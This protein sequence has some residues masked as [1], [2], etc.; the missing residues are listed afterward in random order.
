[1][2]TTYILKY[3]KI[4][5]RIKIEELL[6]KLGPIEHES[7]RKDK[8][9]YFDTFDWRLYR[10]GYHLYLFG[11]RFA[12]YNFR[13]NKME[14]TE[15]AENIKETNFSLR[16]SS[17]FGKIKAV[18]GI[19]EPLRQLDL[20]RIR[21]RYRLLNN[22]NKSIAYLQI[23]QDRVKTERGYKKVDQILQITPLRGY[24]KEV[25]PILIKL[26]DLGFIALME[27]RLKINLESCGKHPA[28]YSSK[29]SINLV[30]QMPA[31][32]AMKQ[33]Y[34]H[35]LELMRKNEHGIIDDI[36]TEFLHDYR[37]SVRR[38]RSGIGQIKN[39]LDPQIIE[40][41]KK[42]YSFLGKATNKLRDLD[43]YL[44][45]E[46]DYKVM[47]PDHLRKHLDPFFNY[48][49]KSRRKELKNLIT[50]F[51]TAG[52]KK[53]L[54]TWESYLRS[55]NDSEISD[56]SHT[57]VIDI[58]RRVIQK[59]NK[60]MLQLGKNILETS[61]DELMHR[62]RIEAKKLRYLLE[63]FSSLFEQD[64]MQV[65]L[66]KLRQLQDNLGEHNDLVV[67]QR[68]L[69]ESAGL[70]TEKGLPAV[71]TI[72]AMGILIGKLS[73]KET[74]VKRAFARIFKRYA[75]KSTQK[76]FRNLLNPVGKV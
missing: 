27:D 22:E 68:Y 14:I 29:I 57:P 9:V 69:E 54:H 30:P 15:D 5:S 11:K 58:A 24:V 35:L 36:D 53:T 16:N 74:Q 63:F 38:T 3:P 43:V 45:S 49:K 72:L 55:E 59:R 20:R 42:I 7:V 67:Q 46:N 70:M 48:L 26:S 44:L 8:Y 50:H 60:K 61:S 13:T 12:L 28:T 39:V 71:R 40:K 41:T 18:T 47:V 10:E 34:L 37:V 19:R 21:Y 23:D 75:A 31:E 52:Y 32:R 51:T 17:L 4:I 62:L 33:I 66:Q 56:S 2:A 65:L 1:M 25:Q 64:K 76:E 73:E 6:S